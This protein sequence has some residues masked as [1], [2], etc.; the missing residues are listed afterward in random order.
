[1]LKRAGQAR[2]KA[3]ARRAGVGQSKSSGLVWIVPALIV[4]VGLIYYCIGYTGF[5]SSWNWDGVSPTH[6]SAG[7][8]NY[9]QL[10]A[11]PVFWGTLR[12][13]LLYFVIVLVAEVLLGMVF[14]ALLHSKVWLGAIY[15]V[16]IFLP[17]VL[18][19]AT[20]APVFRDIFAPTGQFNEVLRFFG[21][22][23]LQRSWLAEPQTALGVIIAIGIWQSTGV[24]FILYFA[25]M[26]QI[27][28]EIIEAARLDGAGAT[29]MFRSIIW[30]S[31]RGTTAALSVLTAIASLKLFDI[32][33]LVTSGG[34]D[35]GTEFLGT[36]IYRVSIP[37][38]QV[39][40]GAALSIVLLVLAVTVAMVLTVGFRLRHR[41]E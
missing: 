19:P 40:Y 29:R 2:R 13:T 4:S 11:D 38:A 12:H 18:A 22:G 35:F 28:G 32:P 27:D 8:G 26:G 5:I 6:Q 30:P 36:F 7:F 20:M 37:Q 17:V 34:P 9:R 41:S 3:R 16:I 15:K 23:V 1:M 33:Y 14:A 10:W 39:G 25:A 31:V 24:A 21:L